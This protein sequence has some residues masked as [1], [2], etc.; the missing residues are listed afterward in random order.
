MANAYFCFTPGLGTLDVNLIGQDP[1]Q[2]CQLS[3]EGAVGTMVEGNMIAAAAWAAQTA[4]TA[5]EL[6][7]SDEVGRGIYAFSVPTGIGLQELVALFYAHPMTAVAA[8]L[9]QQALSWSGS[10]AVGPAAVLAAIEAVVYL[11]RV[12]YTNGLF[13][14]TLFANGVEMTEGVENASVGA[15]LSPGGAVLFA[16]QA[17]THVSGGSYAFLATGDQIPMVGQAMVA[18]VTANTGAI[19]CGGNDLVG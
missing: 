8:V 13:T 19:E 6:L 5:S 15:V 9:G 12:S 18:E 1:S 14:A 16:P 17:M 7:T 11:A 4:I 3:D 2:V 10:V